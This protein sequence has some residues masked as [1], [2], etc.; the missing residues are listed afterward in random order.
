MTI[1]YPD[2]SEM[3]QSDRHF[4]QHNSACFTVTEK[5]KCKAIAFD[6]RYTVMVPFADQILSKIHRVSRVLSGWS[7]SSPSSRRIILHLS[8][9]LSED[10]FEGSLLPRTDAKSTQDEVR[11]V[12]S[13]NYFSVLYSTHCTGYRIPKMLFIW[14]KLWHYSRYVLYLIP[15]LLSAAI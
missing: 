1:C 9:S 4:T 10:C 3:A 8:L 6:F 11:L 2:F 5:C 12:S 7:R 13:Y 15:S 14:C